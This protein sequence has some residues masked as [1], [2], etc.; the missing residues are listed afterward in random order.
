LTR[1]ETADATAP[2]TV[3]VNVLLGNSYKMA[4]DLRLSRYELCIVM[5]NVIGHIIAES[6]LPAKPPE[7]IILKGTG[8]PMTDTIARSRLA[9]LGRITRQVFRTHRLLDTAPGGSA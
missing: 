3:A 6:C 5:A 8:K 9:D 1:L 2:V 4:A 7:G